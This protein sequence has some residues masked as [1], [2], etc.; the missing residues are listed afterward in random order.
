MVS[1]FDQV[2]RRVFKSYKDVT[3]GTEA[4]PLH[5]DDW[6][7]ATIERRHIERVLAYTQG[8]KS[9]AARILDIARTTLDR[10]LAAYGIGGIGG[11]DGGEA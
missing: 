10:K 9:E 8:N 1:A 5:L 6:Q 2:D 3:A 11:G 4:Q 7:L